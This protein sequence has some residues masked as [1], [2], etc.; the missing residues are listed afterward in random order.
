MSWAG[1]VPSGAWRSSSHT[2]LLAQ[3]LAVLTLSP[4]PWRH[5]CVLAWDGD[6]TGP[7]GPGAGSS[8]EAVSKRGKP[9]MLHRLEN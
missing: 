3:L 5:C 9:Q 6:L 8:E 1:R 7:A 2:A 4:F